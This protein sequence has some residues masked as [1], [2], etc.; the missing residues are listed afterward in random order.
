MEVPPYLLHQVLNAL[1]R[2]TY[3]SASNT[4]RFEDTPLGT[5]AGLDAC[6][7]ELLAVAEGVQEKAGAK[8]PLVKVLPL[9]KA[10]LSER[11]QE[12]LDSNND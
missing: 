8:Q 6:F 5:T 4:T 3:Q 11:V 10:A 7:R 1:C 2:L 9:M 12:M